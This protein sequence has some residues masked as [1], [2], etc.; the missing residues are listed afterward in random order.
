M[1]I[2]DKHN[3][4]EKEE[5]LENCQKEH[6]PLPGYERHHYGCD[7]DGCIEWYRSLK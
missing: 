3:E 4:D 7:C 1:L 2:V 6:N 5:I